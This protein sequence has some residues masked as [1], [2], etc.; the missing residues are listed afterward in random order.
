M[1]KIRS[2]LRQHSSVQ[3]VFC[4]QPVYGQEP[5]IIDARKPEGV[6]RATWRVEFANDCFSRKTIRSPTVVLAETLSDCSRPGQQW[7]MYRVR[8]TLGKKIPTLT[9][10]GLMY[11]AGISI[12][13]VFSDTG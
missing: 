9:E 5:A 3:F 1:K 7:R 11:R 8:Q 2:A 12:D 6:E 13:Q 10:E 4:I